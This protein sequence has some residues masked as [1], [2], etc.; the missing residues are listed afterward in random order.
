MKKYL[1]HDKHI[2]VTVVHGTSGAENIMF[3]VHA[4]IK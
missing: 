3:I 2:F 1:F 4:S